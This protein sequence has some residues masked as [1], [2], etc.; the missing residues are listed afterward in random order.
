MHNR[1]LD[2]SSMMDDRMR[3]REDIDRD[4]F[5][6][7]SEDLQ[8]KQS[9]GNLGNERVRGGSRSSGDDM[10]GTGDE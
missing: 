6:E 9:E 10:R 7:S 3:N 2:K 4:M 5:E 8:R 1:D